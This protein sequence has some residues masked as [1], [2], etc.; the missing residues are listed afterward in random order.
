VKNPIKYSLI[1]QYLKNSKAEKYAFKKK[2]EYKSKKK[3]TSF[4]IQLLAKKSDIYLSYGKPMDLFGNDVDENGVSLAPNGMPVDV[5]DYYVSDGKIKNDPQRDRVYTHNLGEVITK[6]YL[7]ENIVL[8]SHLLAFSAFEILRKRHSAKDVFSL[9]EK[10]PEEL[11]IPMEQLKTVVGKL[12]DRLKV[13]ADQDEVKLSNIIQK[14]EIE[15]L[16]KDGIKNVGIFHNNKPL[17][18][19][20][21]GKVRSED[22]ELLYYYHNRLNGYGLEREF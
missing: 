22:L 11:E 15:A 21:D 20:K 8:S 18:I 14:D 2:D 12:V 1:K 16:I 4:L 17:T 6:R 13:L 3:V 10:H 5:K 7:K 9:Q 19:S